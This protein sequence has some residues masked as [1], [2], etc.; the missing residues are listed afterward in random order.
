MD[1]SSNIDHIERTFKKAIDDVLYDEISKKYYINRKANDCYLY[2][3]R[4]DFFLTI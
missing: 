1:S 4:D 3:M 2:S